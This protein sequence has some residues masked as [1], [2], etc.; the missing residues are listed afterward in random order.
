MSCTEFD[1]IHKGQ[2]FWKIPKGIKN[3][4]P[5]MVSEGI[6]FT[7]IS[8]RKGIDIK[9]N[10]EIIIIGV[11]RSDYNPETGWWKASSGRGYDPRKISF[12]GKF[13][14]PKTNCEEYE[15]KAKIYNDKIR[16]LSFWKRFLLFFTGITCIPEKYNLH[17]SLSI[18]DYH[19]IRDKELFKV[20]C[21]NCGREIAVPN[22]NNYKC[23]ICK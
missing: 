8:P 14:R 13:I 20:K 15:S 9:T 3:G 22:P 2:D 11:H 18:S 17:H 1:I 23:Y 21:E 10:E 16:A 5:Q 6:H 7:T 4:V 19:K 12:N